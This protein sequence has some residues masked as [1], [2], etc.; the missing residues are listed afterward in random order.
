MD[1]VV[2]GYEEQGWDPAAETPPPP[3]NTVPVA[4][5]A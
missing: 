5:A 2:Y 1:I 4:D 3:A